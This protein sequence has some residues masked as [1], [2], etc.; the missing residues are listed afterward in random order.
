MSD[1]FT[2]LTLLYTLWRKA[3]NPS[4]VKYYVSN[5]PASTLQ[6]MH[7]L[8]GRLKRRLFGWNFWLIQSRLGLLYIALIVTLEWRPW[9]ISDEPCVIQNMFTRLQLCSISSNAKNFHLGVTV[10]WSGDPSM[11]QG[12][13]P[14]MGMGMMKS[15]R[16]CKAVSID[17]VY[18]F[19]LQKR[20]KFENVRT[21]HHNSW[22]V[23][24]TVRAKRHFASGGL[25]PQ[26]H[27]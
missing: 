5:A 6:Q 20:S 3:P 9:N 11:V 8:E 4:V 2:L 22:P 17:I 27:G 19:W 12:Q 18:R 10:R 25:A 13:S 26:A 16:S 7:V 23:C 24:F 15:P 1:Y 21:I 14:G